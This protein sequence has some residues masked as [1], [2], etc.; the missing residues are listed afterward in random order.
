MIR[1]MQLAIFANMLACCSSCFV[2]LYRYMAHNSPK[3]QE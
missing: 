3:K 2:V 1:D